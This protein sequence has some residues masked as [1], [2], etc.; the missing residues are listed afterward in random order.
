MPI[1]GQVWL[2]SSLAFL[3]GALLCWLIVAR[4]ARAR[5][6]SLQ[7]KLATLIRRQ[8]AVENATAAKRSSRHDED[9]VFGASRA[10]YAD[11]VR[12]L[13]DSL[14]HGYA[15]TSEPQREEPPPPMRGLSALDG[16]LAAP[17]SDTELADSSGQGGASA[18]RYISVSSGSLDAPGRAGSPDGTS[19]FDD[20]VAE[21][22][23]P[24]GHQTAAPLPTRPTVD[25]DRRLVD[26]EDVEPEEPAE[27]PQ[28]P[29]ALADE[30]SG[31]IFT[32]KTIPV[33]AS[34]ISEL[35][36]AQSASV[37]ETSLI[38]DL[39]D[40]DPQ[41]SL[42]SRLDPEPRTELVEP[43]TQLM[44]PATQVV[45]PATQ[46]VEP[47]TQ[48]VEPERTEIHSTANGNGHAP[49]PSFQET[50]VM[51]GVTVAAEAA[52]RA[53]PKRVPG[54][55][56]HQRT[57]FGVL[58][59]PAPAASGND[60]TRALFEPIVPV[61]EEENTSVPP[62]PHRM[63][64][65]DGTVS[66]RGPFGPG[67]AMPLPGGGSPAPEYTIKASV[68]ALRYCTPESPQFGRT[69][70]EVWF[71]SAADAERVGFRPVG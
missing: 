60:P 42:A 34:A 58:T 5:V 63:R 62:P 67:S 51:P 39:A 50:T 14:S 44:E 35:D 64:G 11:E 46:L 19:W 69:V 36:D 9:N 10:A 3:L 32:Q 17:D 66:G 40:D 37:E 54:K 4:P 18:T 8:Q 26:D 55:Q 23:P 56:T 21:D 61:G 30:E 28:P 49:E 70:A 31:T 6:A 2:W 25:I 59:E 29:S 15:P 57:P 47:A 41:E 52:T 38:D 65:G 71:R 33:P 20:E 22:E 12:R 13:N 53:L 24:V 16:V 43:A 1:F 7:T 27:R 45:E 48:L 68:T